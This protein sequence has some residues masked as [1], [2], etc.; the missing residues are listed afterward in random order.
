MTDSAIILANGLLRDPHAKSTHALVRGPSRY[1]VAG[2][3]DA[4]CAGADAGELLDGRRRGIPV[5]SDIDEAQ[6]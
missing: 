4:S 5:F 2:V 1:R 3:V 6:A